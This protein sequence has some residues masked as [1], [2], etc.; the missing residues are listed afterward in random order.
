MRHIAMTCTRKEPLCRGHGGEK[1]IG[2][3]QTTLVRTLI[4]AALPL[5]VMAL[6]V[7]T[8]W[9]EPPVAGRDNLREPVYRVTKKNNTGAN[10]LATSS[11]TEPVVE[12]HPLAPALR[13]AMS[14]YENI[15]NNVTDYTAT[16]VKRERIDGK[17]GEHEYIFAKV[18]HQ[19]VVEGQITT[20]FSVYMYFLKPDRIKGRE[21]LYVAGHNNNKLIAHE[22]SNGVVSAMIS[23]ITVSLDPTSALAMRGNRYPITEVGIENLVSKLIEVARED[24]QYGECE[25]KFFKGA[26]INGRVCTCIQVVHPVPRKNFRF[27][28]ARVFIDD[29]RQVPIRYEAYD[30]PK[31]QGGAPVLLE[32]YTYLDLKLNVGLT[33]ADFERGNPKYGF[34]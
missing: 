8:C 11:D 16:L 28:L 12:E 1:E 25:V 9:A 20:P 14:G 26:K 34:R 3:P 7:A 2:M 19:R 23:N 24:M 29:E 6:L 32:E 27:H 4:N 13:V 10:T 31:T 21:V 17:L 30:W 15:R 18:R 33:D 22:G 5:A